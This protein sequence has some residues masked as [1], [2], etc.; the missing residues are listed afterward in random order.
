MLVI[1][2]LSRALLACS[3]L[4]PRVPV[5]VVVHARTRSPRSIA[6]AVS[7]RSRDRDTQRSPARPGKGLTLSCAGAAH[8]SRRLVY[9]GEV[10]N[11]RHVALRGACRGPRSVPCRSAPT[12][13]G[14]TRLRWARLG[15]SLESDLSASHLARPHSHCAHAYAACSPAALYLRSRRPVAARRHAHARSRTASHISPRLRPPMRRL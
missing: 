2:A 8:S 1:L 10:R 5:S 6:I 14:P 9:H 4:R 15:A 13:S 3:C 12:G 7:P 11:A